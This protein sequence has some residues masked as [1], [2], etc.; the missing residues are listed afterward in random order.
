MI[1][2]L[3]NSKVFDFF[4]RLKMGGIDLTQSVVRQI[5]VPFREAWNSMVT[6]HGV[7]YTAL[8]AVRALER[9]L[10][11]NE[12]DLCVLWYGVPEIKNADNYYKTAADVREEIDKIIFQMYGLTSAE[13]KM[14]RNSFKA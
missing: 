10:Y 12:T 13:E 11:R 8:D 4:V 6:L 5:P 3:F 7:D 1:L 2:A 14:V 9:L